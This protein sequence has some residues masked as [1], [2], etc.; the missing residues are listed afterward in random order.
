MTPTLVLDT[1]VLIAGLR[2]SL[3][4]SYVLTNLVG[5]GHFDIGLTA[6][7][8]LEYEATCLKS[9]PALNFTADDVMELLD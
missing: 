4:A 5:S 3:G 7:L 8:V 2:S 1:S 9:L 6:A